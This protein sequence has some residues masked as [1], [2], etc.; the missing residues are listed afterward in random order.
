MVLVSS[1]DAITILETGLTLLLGVELEASD[2]LYRKKIASTVTA[3]EHQ[4]DTIFL[5]LV[6]ANHKIYCPFLFSTRRPIVQW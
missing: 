5:E 1:P 4:V 2:S 3:I 6:T